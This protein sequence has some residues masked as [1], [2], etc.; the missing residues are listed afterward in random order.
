ML[1]QLIDFAGISLAGFLDEGDGSRLDG[2]S[3]DGHFFKAGLEVLFDFSFGKAFELK[4]VAGAGKAG[5]HRC[6]G[7][8]WAAVLDRRRGLR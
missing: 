8:I 5:G 1:K 3:V 4:L 6:R 7:A 2:R